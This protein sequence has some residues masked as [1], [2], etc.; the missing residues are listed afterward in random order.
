MLHLCVHV[1]LIQSVHNTFLT[2]V[3]FISILLNACYL[4]NICVC[5]CFQF[6]TYYLYV[7][8]YLIP[9]VHNISAALVGVCLHTYMYTCI[10]MCTLIHTHN[11]T[12]IS[13]IKSIHVTCVCTCILFQ[14][15]QCTISLLHLYNNILLL[16]TRSISN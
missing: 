15:T 12:C 6:T 3:C 16:T 7:Y 11:D 14:F 2:P 9:S 5:A 4:C 1:Y 13:I 8:M 10:S